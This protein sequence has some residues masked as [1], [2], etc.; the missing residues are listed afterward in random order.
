MV[1]SHTS[2]TVPTSHSTHSITVATACALHK[3]ITHVG[4]AQ[5]RRTYVAGAGV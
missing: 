4:G 3:I 1:L 5:Q 2:S